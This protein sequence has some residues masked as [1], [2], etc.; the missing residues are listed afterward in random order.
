MRPARRSN[1]RR[2]SREIDNYLRSH[3]KNSLVVQWLRLH[4]PNVGRAEFNPWSG[5]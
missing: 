2:R 5:N 3:G 1:G 4:T